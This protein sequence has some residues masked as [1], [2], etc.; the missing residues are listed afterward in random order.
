MRIL[1]ASENVSWATEIMDRLDNLVLGFYV[2]CDERR[3]L[4]DARDTRIES[5]NFMWQTMIEWNWNERPLLIIEWNDLQLSSFLLNESICNFSILSNVT[6][7]ATLKMIEP[8][9]Y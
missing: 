1:E 3:F 8:C 6:Y 9:D 4:P 7:I 5:L 2:L